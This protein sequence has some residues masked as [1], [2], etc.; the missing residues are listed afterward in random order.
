MCIL[1]VIAFFEKTHCTWS[2]KNR[3]QSVKIGFTGTHIASI[4]H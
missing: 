3:N 4:I 2:L 1:H